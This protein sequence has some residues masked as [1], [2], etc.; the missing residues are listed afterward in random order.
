MAIEGVTTLWLL[1]DPP[2]SLGRA[3]P[4]VAAAILLVVHLSTLLVQVPLHGSLERQF[5]AERAHRLVRTNWVRTIG[6]SARGALAIVMLVVTVVR[7]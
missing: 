5:D 7:A 6:W 1:I 2:T 3:L 4:L